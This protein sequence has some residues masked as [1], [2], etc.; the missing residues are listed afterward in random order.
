DV[1]GESP[2]AEGM[3]VN[4]PAGGSVSI[5]CSIKVG[6]G[7]EGTTLNYVATAAL[8]GFLPLQASALVSVVAGPTGVAGP[9][10][11]DTIGSAG[12]VTAGKVCAVLVDNTGT[13]IEITNV[14]TAPVIRCHGEPVICG[15][16]FAACVGNSFAVGAGDIKAVNLAPSAEGGPFNLCR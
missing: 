15:E 16:A 8:G 11:P 4:V 5:G 12:T 2:L 14:G 13:R 10:T 6:Q 9:I 1:N 7:T 3:S